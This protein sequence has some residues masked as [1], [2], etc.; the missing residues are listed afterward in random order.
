M[1]TPRKGESKKSFISRCMEVVVGEGKDPDQAYAIC[2]SMWDDRDLGQESDSVIA[3]KRQEQPRQKSFSRPDE[4][5]AN[6]N[7]ATNI[8]KLDD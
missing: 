4:A 7:Q 8:G 1:P 2:N 3:S 5:Q 6:W